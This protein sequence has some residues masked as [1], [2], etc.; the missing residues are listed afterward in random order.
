[1]TDAKCQSFW[2]SQARADL[3][4][5]NFWNGENIGML[6]ISGMLGQT[7]SVVPFRN[8]NLKLNRML[9]M[10][11]QTSSVIPFWNHS[12]HFWVFAGE[13]I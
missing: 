13:Y 4:Y 6:R 7:P 8:H 12:D 2:E 11:G 5:G 3:N 1:M 10:L 9:K